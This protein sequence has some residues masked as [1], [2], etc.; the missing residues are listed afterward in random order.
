MFGSILGRLA[1]VQTQ[2]TLTWCSANCAITCPK[3]EQTEENMKERFDKSVDKAAVDRRSFLSVALG[4]CAITPLA[5][6]SLQLA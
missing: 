6:L 4:T 2:P 1:M 3:G 5:P